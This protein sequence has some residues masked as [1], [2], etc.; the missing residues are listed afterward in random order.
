MNPIKKVLV[1][2]P[3]ALGDVIQTI[4]AVRAIKS[5]IP[6][7]EISWVVSDKFRKIVGMV[8]VV[9][10]IYDFKRDKWGNILFLPVTLIEMIALIIK[11][12]M[13]RFDICFDFQGLFRSGLITWLSGA[14]I[15]AGFA[16]AREFASL[17]YTQKCRIRRDSVNSVERYMGLVSEV[18]GKDGKQDII[19]RLN[20]PHPTLKL[21]EVVWFKP[22]TKGPKVCFMPGSQWPSKRW[23]VENYRKLVFFLRDKVDARMII[24]GTADEEEIGNRIAYGCEKAVNLCGKTDMLSLAGILSLSDLVITNDNGAM[25]L[26]AALGKKMICFY[27]PSSPERTGPVGKGIFIFRSKLPCAPCFKRKCPKLKCMTDIPVSLVASKALEMLN[28]ENRGSK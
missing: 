7:S 25:H 19:Y 18:A 24:T 21:G 3:S 23:D 27:G 11:I 20:V 8:D 5:F 16:D 28:M 9:N 22:G 17:C 14:K 1:I 15:K 6:E 2:K 13:K 12:R 10:E 4:P 26:A